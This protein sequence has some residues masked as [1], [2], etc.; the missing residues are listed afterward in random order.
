MAAEEK[1]L[2]C[3]GNGYPDGPSI[4]YS[5]GVRQVFRQSARRLLPQN[6]LPQMANDLLFIVFN[7]SLQNGFRPCRHGSATDANQDQSEC[8]CSYCF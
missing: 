1:K 5:N 8:E 4:G 7:P 2:A 3:H 6:V